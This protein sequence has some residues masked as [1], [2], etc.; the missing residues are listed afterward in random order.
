[1]SEV[2]LFLAIEIPPDIVR[3]VESLQGRLAR[4]MEG[5]RWTAPRKLHITLKF[6]GDLPDEQVEEVIEFMEIVAEK[7][8]AFDL[9]ISG[10]GQFPGSGTPSVLWVGCGEKE[11]RE[12]LSLQ[13]DLDHA[14]NE[15][16]VST[17]DREYVPH[18]TIGRVDDNADLGNYQEIMAGEQ[19]N[20]LGSFTVR[21]FTL[22][23]SELH[24][25]GARYD[26]LYRANLENGE[27]E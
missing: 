6:I 3:N 9:Q 17:E 22:F 8:E 14:M 24:P 21:E 25:S 13:E 20:V 23:K 27:D 16:G 26:A 2:R 11:G 12:L 4:V 10:V 18:V 5:V 19:G 7:H 15:V 1:M